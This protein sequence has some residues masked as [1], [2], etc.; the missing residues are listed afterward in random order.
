MVMR[1]S[2][3]QK[4]AGVVYSQASCSRKTVT[5]PPAGNEPAL[6]LFFKG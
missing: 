4:E 6:L 1:A 2:K 3:K 5:L